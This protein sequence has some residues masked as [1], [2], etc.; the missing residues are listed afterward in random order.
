MSK[1]QEMFDDATIAEALA[2]STPVKRGEKEPPAP[3]AEKPVEF[4]K[5]LDRPLRFEGGHLQIGD[6][7]ELV[8][9]ATFIMKSAAVKI[10]GAQTASDVVV[11]L[12]HGM[13]AGL[14][15]TQ[16]IK[17][18]MIVNGKPTIWGDCLL[19]IV[20]NSGE[21]ETLTETMDDDQ[22]ATCR[23]VRVAKLVDGTFARRETIRSFSVEDAKTAGLW[24]KSGPWKSYP[25]RMLQ[26]RARGFALRDAFADRLGGLFLGEDIM[27]IN[28]NAF[29]PSKMRAG[30]AAALIGGEE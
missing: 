16:C 7:Q 3:A 1:E 27:D 25:K 13:E 28:P 8:R 18:V 9:T 29:D 22:T 19:A 11:A 14:S 21:L 5:M 30:S 20:M 4:E 17:N 12:M 26:V 6:T 23:V 15:P 10:S 24:G 2:Q